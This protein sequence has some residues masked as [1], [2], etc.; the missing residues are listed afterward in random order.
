M[1]VDFS[2]V[3]ARLVHQGRYH[4]NQPK[5]FEDHTCIEEWAYLGKLNAYKPCFG[6]CT[7]VSKDEQSD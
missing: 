3:V 6:V 2:K 5:V 4:G 1:E 7:Y